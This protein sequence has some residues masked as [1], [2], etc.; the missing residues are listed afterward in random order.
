MGK[1]V[2]IV[3]DSTLM[4]RVLSDIIEHIE[5]YQVA[6][7]AAN[8]EE[9]LAL[10]R[11]HKDIDVVFLDLTMPKVGGIEVLRTC[12]DER[13]SA[14]IIVFSSVAEEGNQ[15]TL[16]ALELG[17]LDFLKKPKNLFQT[18]D[19]F[20]NKLNKTL[21]IAEEH[22]QVKKASEKKKTKAI[23][24]KSVSKSSA[25]GNAFGQIVALA[26]STGGP[27]ALQ[28]VIPFLPAN[29]PVPVVVVQHMPEGFTKSLAERLDE[30]SEIHVEEASDG[31]IVQAGSVYIAKGGNHISLVTDNRGITKIKLTDE[32]PV[33]GLRPY[34][35]KMYESLCDTNYKEIVC[36]VL[37][38]MG[39]DGTKGIGRLREQK[40]L[41]VIAQDMET[42]TVYGMPRAVANAGYTDEILP[43]QEIAVAI[44]KKVGV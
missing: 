41:Y 44:T 23:S 3:D 11:N 39:A 36:V 5:G 38:G 12:R 21:L 14:N 13:I 6:Y 17:A 37:T 26:C 31:A 28:Q 30:L 10:L 32:A 2:A 7:T 34:A 19:D 42:S 27:K 15:E 29:L 18:S 20:V 8:G 25:T 35:N 16:Q 22:S 1:N 43:L 24:T 9:A 40:N 33:Q 4:R